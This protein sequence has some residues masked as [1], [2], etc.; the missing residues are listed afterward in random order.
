MSI[1][2][3][4][5][6]SGCS[7]LERVVLSD[8]TGGMLLVLGTSFVMNNSRRFG[9]L[10]TLAV[11]LHLEVHLLSLWWKHNLTM[12]VILSDISAVADLD[13]SITSAAW[14]LCVW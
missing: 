13:D 7:A 14:L 12:L 3:H 9:L 2:L 10:D 6:D 11:D 4:V 5:I 8:V 1:I